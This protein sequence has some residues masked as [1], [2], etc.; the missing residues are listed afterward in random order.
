[1]NKLNNIIIIFPIIINLI[2][3]IL[4][5]FPFK[6]NKFHPISL[7]FI[8]IIL[9][10]L[11]CFKINLLIKSIIS[12]ILFLI[13][14]GGLIVIFMYITRLANNE[15]FSFN[16]K[17][18][19]INI[20]KITPIIL[21]LLITTLIYKQIIFINLIESF[22]LNNWSEIN[23]KYINIIY[24]EINNNSSYFI[25]IYLYYSIICIINI[26][27]KLKAPLRQILF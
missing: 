13:I 24:K 19:I 20:N 2:I 8:L 7:I 22:N 14:I 26:C 21:L 23:Y 15:L 17:N 16:L 12:F 10:F 11:V 3:I 1:M 6:N 9:T 5:I 18:F 25:I 4:L 27:Y